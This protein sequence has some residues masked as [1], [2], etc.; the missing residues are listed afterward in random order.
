MKLYS[1][2]FFVGACLILS[3]A[4]QASIV[5]NGDF[6]TGDFS[7][8]TFTPDANSDPSMTA[9]VSVFNGSNAFTVNPG[10][11]AG[12]GPEAGGRLS[13]TIALIG[14]V[15]YYI[16]ARMIAIQTLTQFNNADGGTITISINGETQHVFD[17][18]SITGNTTL[19]DS[20]LGT[21]SA[22]T[23]GNYELD[24][25]FTRRFLNFTPV[26][27]HYLDDVSVS[28]VPVPAAVWLFG[29]ALAGLGWLRRSGMH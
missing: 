14:G 19:T 4:A 18:G 8:W 20:F 25:Y 22:A 6:E 17:V 1:G 13:Q 11:N 28:A 3:S 5:T 24:F 23:T 2:V 16:S 7:G 21:Y 10:S 26:I 9:G 29:S 15:D 12:P 27:N